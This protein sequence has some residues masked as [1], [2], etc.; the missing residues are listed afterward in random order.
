MEVGLTARVFYGLMIDS[1][2]GWMR[3]TAPFEEEHRAHNGLKSFL[4]FI[5]F[6]HEIFFIFFSFSYDFIRGRRRLISCSLKHKISQHLSLITFYIVDY[7][8]FSRYLY[9]KVRCVFVCGHYNVLTQTS[10]SVLKLWGTQGYLWL[11]YDLTEVI[12]LVGVTFK[13]K[14]YFFSKNTLCHSFR[15]SVIPSALVS[16]LP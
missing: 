8:W 3:K 16:F 13:Q 4:S 12:N 14:K 7:P 10:P 6:S 15:I 2:S 9:Y 5:A 11:P 1:S